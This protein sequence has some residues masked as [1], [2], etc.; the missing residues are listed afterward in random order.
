MSFRIAIV[1]A[2]GTGKTTL[3]EALAK[4]VGLP[5]IREGARELSELMEVQSPDQLGPILA[6]FLQQ[7]IL[8]R[9]IVLENYFGD[10]ISDRSTVDCY[11][12]WQKLFGGLVS[13]ELTNLYERL[14]RVHARQYQLIAFCPIEFPLEDDSFRYLNVDFQKEIDRII[15]AC[16]TDWGLQTKTVFV[17]GETEVRVRQVKL[18][19]S[20][21][22]AAR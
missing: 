8:T 20:R 17:A 22:G 19:L 12:Y 3:A 1:G 5:L 16:L 9:Q 11:A 13:L 21:I 7:A 2:Q 18:R 4:E 6:Q 10:F 14:A 15:R